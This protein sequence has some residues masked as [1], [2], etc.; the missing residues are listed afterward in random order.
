MKKTK[1]NEYDLC[2]CCGSFHPPKWNGDCREDANRFTEDELDQKHG[3][4]GWVEVPHPLGFTTRIPVAFPD[5]SGH[6]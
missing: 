2:G 5:K 4:W 3:A 1:N 6:H